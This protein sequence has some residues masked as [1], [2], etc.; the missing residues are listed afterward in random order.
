MSGD[1]SE[2]DKQYD[3]SQKKLD[4][5]RQK[6]EVP[7]SVDL[8]TS[9]AYFGFLVVGSLAGPASIL[10]IGATLAALLARADSFSTQVFTGSGGL[11][12]KNMLAEMGWALAPWM[13]L[14]GVI[15][16]L[17]VIIQRGLVF[18]PSKLEPKLSRISPIKGFTNKFGR[19][20]LFEFFKSA[21]KLV[22]Y[23]IVL[24][25]F[26]TFQFPEIIGTM[27]MAPA[28]I[29][30]EFLGMALQLLF[31]V[32]LVAVSIG[33][34]DWFFQNAQHTR[35]NRMS[36]KELMDEHKNSEGDPMMKQQRRQ[37]AVGFAM[38]QMLADV[39]DADV[40][41][42]NPTHY[43]VALKWERGS[44]RAPICVAKGVDEIA[45]RIRELAQTHEVPVHSD[46]P[47]ARLLF[48]SVEIGDEIKP[49]HYRAVAAAIRFAEKVRTKV[50][51]T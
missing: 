6:G 14:P 39:P 28:L 2:E 11:F 20:G 12:A 31:I 23:S 15:A 4:D 46:P 41:I 37:K 18:A 8:T 27:I 13:V 36:R 5:A 34:V 40:I 48:A 38:N 29:A 9:A 3:P 44:G 49:D 32:F 30:S 51:M 7:K 50:R 22:I 17:S 33:A 24:G 25:F 10:A 45:A 42:V 16:L 43:A 1:D 35:K 21:G 26:L 47:T 19:E